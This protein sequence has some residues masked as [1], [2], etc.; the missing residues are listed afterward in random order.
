ML[1]FPDWNEKSWT[2]SSNRNK[3][4]LSLDLDKASTAPKK[5][6]QRSNLHPYTNTKIMIVWLESFEDHLNLPISMICLLFVI[7]NNDLMVS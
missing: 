3:R 6:S 4:T 7:R 1:F 2:D 5:S